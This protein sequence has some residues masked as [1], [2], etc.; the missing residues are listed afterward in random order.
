[1]HVA[2]SAGSVRLRALALAAVI[3]VAGAAAPAPAQTQH[4][5][6]AT[7]QL[8]VLNGLGSVDLHAVAPPLPLG[9]PAPAGIATLV[10][11]S[12]FDPPGPTIATVQLF[13]SQVVWG[14]G[15]AEYFGSGPAG[16]D[17]YYIH[18]APQGPLGLLHFGLSRTFAGGPCGAAVPAG[19][20]I[21]GAAGIVS[22]PTG[23]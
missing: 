23:Y 12:T 5:V 19:I 7:G 2:V 22:A 14:P 18:L 3:W 9:L 21:I 15:G 10:L 4:V 17:T 13:C 1:M 20:P 16:E 8:A 11:Q 6:F